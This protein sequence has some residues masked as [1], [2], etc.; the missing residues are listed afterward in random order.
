[1]IPNDVGKERCHCAGATLYCSF[2]V[3]PKLNTGTGNRNRIYTLEAFA[4][5]CLISEPVSIVQLRIGGELV[6]PPLG[7]LSPP[8]PSQHVMKIAKKSESF[9][10]LPLKFTC[11]FIVDCSAEWNGN[12]HLAVTGTSEPRGKR[13]GLRPETAQELKRRG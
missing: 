11:P 13:R 6:A 12:V 9:V 2:H 1:M 7:S 8:L 10:K 5:S 3:R 4:K